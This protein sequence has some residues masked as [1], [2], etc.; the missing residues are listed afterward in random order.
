MEVIVGKM[1]G[2]CA[3]VLNAVTKTEKILSKSNEKVYCLGS[4]VHNDNVIEK[5]KEK[6]LIQVNDIIE[7]PNS[8]K[9]IIRAHGVEKKI[10]NLAKNKKI[11]LYDLT[12]P[13]VKKIHEIV[14]KN[15]EKYILIIGNS[16]H[17][18]VIGIR[19]FSGQ[20]TSIIEN[21]EDVDKVFNNIVKSGL[22]EVLVV[23]QTTESSDKFKKICN[24]IL[25]LN[26]NKLNIEIKNTI[27][28][29]TEL[30]QNETYEMSKKVDFM[31]I[32]GG[33]NSSNTNKLYEIS[34]K[35][36]KTIFISD[37]REFESYLTNNLN[38]IKKYNSI[39]IMAGASTPKDSIKEIVEIISKL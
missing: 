25:E 16:K 23:S 24:K 9:L 6:G 2:F 21:L 30:R 8:A 18:E 3:G 1:A 17:P 38:N 29:A 11:D 13:K 19:G 10:Y 20:N 15:N 37:S 28:R 7:T 14:E 26:N 35:N 5:L 4:L 27:C 39:G 33:K 12:C 22:K 34:N 31:I 36:C 32:I